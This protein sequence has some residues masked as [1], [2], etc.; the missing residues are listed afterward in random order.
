METINLKRAWRLGSELA[1]SG[2][3]RIYEASADGGSVAVVKLVPKAP[4]ASRELLFEN[5]S[6]LANVIP[7]L[8]SGEWRNYYA[9]AMPRAEKSLRQHLQDAGGKLGVDEA[10]G[11]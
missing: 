2:F 3:G 6:G 8:D 1:S 11:V 4:G 7:I 5:M 9:L 10:V